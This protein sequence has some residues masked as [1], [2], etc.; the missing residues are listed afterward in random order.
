MQKMQNKDEIFPQTNGV[1]S[2]KILC[3][4]KNRGKDRF[5]GDPS[6][7]LYSLIVVV[8]TAYVSVT[9]GIERT[10]LWIKFIA[11]S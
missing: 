5:S 1:K 11:W 8:G 2:A 3:F 4:R 10:C 7:C 6:Y 9:H